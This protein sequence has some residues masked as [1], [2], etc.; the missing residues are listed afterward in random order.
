VPLLLVAV[1]VLTV[2]AFCLIWTAVAGAITLFYACNFF[3]SR[4]MSAYEVNVE[5]SESMDDLDASLR[6][7]AKL[8]D[9]GLLTDKEYEQKRADL[10]HR[11]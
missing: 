6:K 4:G 10:I 11:R 5:S 2:G 1:V 7:L 8:K 9:D 3:S